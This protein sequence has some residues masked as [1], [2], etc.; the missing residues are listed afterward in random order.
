MTRYRL[1]ACLIAMFAVVLVLPAATAEVPLV[2]PGD[3]VPPRGYARPPVHLKFAATTSPS[4]GI[5]P[6]KIRHA[7]GLNLVNNKGAGQTIAVVDA[8]DDP[9]IEADLAVFNAHY[10]LSPC[11]VASGCLRKIYA[12]GSKPS[13]NAGWA[14]EISLDV[15]WAH[16]IA[17]QAHILLVEA[18]S[19]SLTDLL[20]AVDVAVRSGAGVVSMSWGASEFSGER[21]FDTHFAINGVTFLAASGDS[22]HGA[23]YPATSPYIV[24]VGGTS[25]VADASGNYVSEKAWSYSSGGLSA[26]E[27]EPSYQSSL[28]IPND[29]SGKRGSPDVAYDAAGFLLYDSVPYQGFSGWFLAAGTSAGAPQWGAIVAIA[30]SLRRA[31]GKATLSH[32]HFALYGPAKANY[33]GNYHD[34]SSGTNGTCGTLCT[35]A[36]KYDYVTGLGSPRANGLIPFLVSQ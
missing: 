35:A 17:P 36:V 21:T 5:A 4:G 9:N 28:P 27:L 24:G 33:A 6:W 14:V 20:H 3:H 16:A 30:N 8:Y 18:A 7:Y 22:G 32:T 19:N 15:E 1:Q 26:Y 34:V 11:T 12:S 10:G 25:L 13:A 29:S 23:E 2:S 31:Q